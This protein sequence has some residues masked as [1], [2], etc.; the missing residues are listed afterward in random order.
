[1]SVKDL[2]ANVRLISAYWWKP[3]QSAGKRF[4]IVHEF[5]SRPGR[6]ESVA[7]TEDE[8]VQQIMDHIEDQ[9]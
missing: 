5:D 9:P 7:P 8:A 2:P 3:P 1:M 6:F 4:V